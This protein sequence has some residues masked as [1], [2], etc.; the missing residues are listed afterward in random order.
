M[1]LEIVQPCERNV[2]ERMLRSKRPL[3][4]SEETDI[5]EIGNTSVV[6]SA[7]V[8]PSLGEITRQLEGLERLDQT[9][10]TRTPSDMEDE[11]DINRPRLTYFA[12]FSRSL[13]DHA[14]RPGAWQSSKILSSHA[15]LANELRVF[16]DP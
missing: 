3:S 4:P 9:R 7:P 11:Q 10:L 1:R 2:G 16:D 6:Q 14:P 8:A 12:A 15:L 13:P 5:N